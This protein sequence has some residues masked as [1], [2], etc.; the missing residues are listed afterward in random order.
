ME[1][2]D[3]LCERFEAAWL[4]DRQP[5]IEEFLDGVGESVRP[6]LLRELLAIE[7]EYRA[8]S[9][10]RPLPDEYLGRFS[11]PADLVRRVFAELAATPSQRSMAVTCP[12]GHTVRVRRRDA[13]G[14]GN[15]PVCK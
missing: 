11:Q 12:N 9:G 6:V 5:R 8:A 2:I 7:L 15:C 3:R 1:Q 10:E 13:S 4:S 14:S